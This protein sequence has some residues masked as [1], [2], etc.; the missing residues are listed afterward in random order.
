MGPS[1]SAPPDRPM[2]LDERLAGLAEKHRADKVAP[3]EGEDPTAPPPTHAEAKAN[4]EAA[5]PGAIWEPAD[6]V[7]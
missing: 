2:T 4:L 5:F 7:T 6:P 1:A 3:V